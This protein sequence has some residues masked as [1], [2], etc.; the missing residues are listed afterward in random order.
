MTIL[1]IN[2]LAKWTVIDDFFSGRNPR[3]NYPLGVGQL[4]SLFFFG[5]RFPAKA[6]FTLWNRLTTIPWSEKDSLGR[7]LPGHPTTWNFQEGVSE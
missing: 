4:S 6:L 2:D 5:T 3:S 1:D 7:P